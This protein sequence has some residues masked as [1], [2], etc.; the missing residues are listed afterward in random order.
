MG[1]FAK[2]WSTRS[3]DIKVKKKRCDFFGDFGFEQDN[4]KVSNPKHRTLIIHYTDE[5]KI[6]VDS[7]Q[8]WNPMVDIDETDF[9][10]R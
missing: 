2:M 5:G 3:L 6:V 8:N 10:E 1:I 7:D 4:R 9:E